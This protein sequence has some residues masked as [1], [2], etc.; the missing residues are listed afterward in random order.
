MKHHLA[1]AASLALMLA[2]CSGSSGGEPKKADY[3]IAFSWQ[4]A[5]CETAPGK[6]ECKS[7]HAGRFDASNFSLHGLWPQPGTN[8]YCGV[9]ERDKSTDQAGRWRDLDTPFIEESV[10]KQLQEAMPGTQSSLHKHEWIKHGTCYGSDIDAYYRDSLKVLGWLNRSSLRFLFDA[11]VG[12]ELTYGDME[13]ALNRDFGR[14]AGKRLRISCKRDE[15]SGRQ[16]I[17]EMTLGL[18]GNVSEATNLG[19][20]IENAPETDQGCPVGIVD[21]VGLQ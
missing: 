16:L 2:G 10:W 19:Q 13:D 6:R 20:L 11:N 17:V 9:S 7:Q 5:F 12:K 1:L 8:V 3:V 18:G 4:P 21:P 14:G 15:D